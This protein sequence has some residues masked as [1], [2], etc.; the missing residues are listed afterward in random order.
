MRDTDALRRVLIAIVLAG[1][2]AGALDILYA[3]AYHGLRG[4]PAVRILQSVASG[5][6]GRGAYAGGAATAALG[7]TVHCLITT[8][9]AATYITAS[10]RL[11]ALAQRPFR[12]GPLYGLV[13]YAV[14]NYVVVPLSAAP[15]SGRFSWIGLVGGLLAHML[16]VGLPIA[17]FARWAARRI[18][19]AIQTAAVITPAS[20]G[21]RTSAR[22]SQGT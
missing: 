17:L 16:L 6:L 3:I 18:S 11:P 7:L 2:I 19:V 12:W 5:L 15:G 4:I 21:Y 1:L 20:I 13:L 9:M 10:R 8:I 22:E 14:M